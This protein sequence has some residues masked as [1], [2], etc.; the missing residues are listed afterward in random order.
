[1]SGK[2]CRFFDTCS[3][4]IC[5]EDPESLVHC[6]W[7][8]DEE[9]C[10]RADYAGVS[11]I[12][13]QKRIARATGRN[14][15]RGC[16]TMAILDHPCAI[17][18]S[19]KGFDPEKGEI[20]EARAKEWIAKH[21]PISA[22]R[23]AASRAHGFKKGNPVVRPVAEDQVPKASKLSS[24]GNPESLT[25]LD[26]DSLKNGDSEPLGGLFDILEKSP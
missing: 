17:H 24:I 13:R 26:E 11:W 5:P 9:V 12:K 3:A 4:P 19:I 20:S 14:F 2:G 8:P 7:F 1:M 6:A 18:A 22:K 15:E 21:P 10:K 16:F 23:R 25:G